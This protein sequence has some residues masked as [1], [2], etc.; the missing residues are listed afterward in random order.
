[1]LPVSHQICLSPV[2]SVSE[3]YHQF[4]S[5]TQ[6]SPVRNVPS[7]PAMSPVHQQCHQSVSNVPQQCHQYVNNVISPSNDI[8]VHNN[9]PSIP[10]IKTIK[11]FDLTSSLQ[12]LQ[13]TFFAGLCDTIHTCLRP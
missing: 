13:S 3:R 2:Q 5:G 11:M 1:M 6:S 12:L 10:H 7:P 8:F 9:M 4:V